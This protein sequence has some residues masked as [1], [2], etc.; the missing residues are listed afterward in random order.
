MGHVCQEFDDTTIFVK[1]PLLFVRHGVTVQIMK[2]RITAVLLFIAVF[3][4]ACGGASTTVTGVAGDIYG[5]E[6]A[7]RVDETVT[8][9]SGR[10][11]NLLAPV[12]DAF[13]CETG[14]DVEVRWGS[15][16][17]L[18]LLL[19][20]EGEKT[21]AD[22]FLS[23][24]PGPVGFLE[25]KD[26]LGTISQDVLDLVEPQNRSAE[27]RWIGFSGRKRVLVANLDTV[28]DAELPESVFEL[29]DP[30]YK[31]R[32]AIAATNGSFLDWF[33]VFRDQFGTDTATEWL[34]A[35]VENDA[36]SYANNRAIVSAVGLGEVDMGLVNHYYNY[37]VA[38]A[39][40]ESHRA[41]NHDLGDDDIGSLLIITAASVTQT[42]ENDPVAGQLLSYLLSTPVQE[43]FT[44]ETFEYPLASGVALNPVLPK[45]AA[46]EIG[47]VDF[48]A[49][50]G[51][52]EDTLAI[53]EASG[54]LN[55]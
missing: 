29:T 18:A 23:K 52:F 3:A 51:G 38:A 19:A 24:S 20:E 33:T 40:G 14:I 53:I 35:M 42:S 8:V 44:N 31:G 46:L 48:D 36:H 39:E 32:V 47:S 30:I 12:L 37:Q 4:S 28:E 17:D 15:S 22:I 10:T 34:N 25:S 27:G 55:Q 50:G 45:L 16:T 21:N 11:E 26:L 41:Q 2:L 1:K 13:Q 43:Y 7:D 54:I 49:L 5:G 9:Y 6:C